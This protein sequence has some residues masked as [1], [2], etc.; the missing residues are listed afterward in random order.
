MGGAFTNLGVSLAQGLR[1]VGWDAEL[2]GVRPPQI[3]Y[4]GRFA[5]EPFQLLRARRSA[6]SVPALVRYLRSRRPHVVLSLSTIINVPTLVAAMIARSQAAVVVTE[7]TRLSDA[8]SSESGAGVKMRLTPPLVRRLYPHAAGLVAVSRTALADPIL[9]PV[10]D[11]IPHT[12]IGNPYTWDIEARA[13]HG[14]PHPWLRATSRCPTL[15]AAGALIPG[16][17]FALLIRAMARLR[18]RGVEAR[19]VILGEGEERP[20]L[21]ALVAELGLQ[22]SVDLPGFEP[23]P[24][25]SMGAA[26]GFVLASRVEGSPMVLLE[27]MRLGRPIVATEAAGATAEIVRGG[28]SAIIVPDGDVALLA[29]ALEVVVRD[30]E[31]ARSL[32]AEAHKLSDDRSPGTVARRYSDFFEHLLD[33]RRAA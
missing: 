10:L 21:E 18:E 11:K 17:R 6:T 8:T 5:D 29:E 25:P 16:K 19:L 14:Q 32:G 31:R 2:L 20:A 22:G 28:R 4:A 1:Q 15:V 13:G 33:S 23:N 26:D 24:Y 3:E 27:A 7:H 30:R 9:A 12:V